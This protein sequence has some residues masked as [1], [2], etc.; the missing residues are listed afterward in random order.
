ME[1]ERELI[2]EKEECTL[3]DLKDLITK[4]HKEVMSE[5]ARI[6]NKCGSCDKVQKHGPNLK[7]HKERG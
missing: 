2:V 6:K 3:N 1:S 5:M 7:K 4:N